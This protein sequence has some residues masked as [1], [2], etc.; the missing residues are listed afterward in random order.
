MQRLLIILLAV[1]G[2]IAIVSGLSGVILG[3]ALIP[4]GAPV[5]TS[6]DS[7]YRFAFV[8]WLAAGVALLWSLFPLR[9]RKSVTQVTL[10]LAFIGGLARL[11]SVIAIG[12]PHPVF[13]TT[14]ALELVVVPLVFLWHARF[15]QR[16]ERAAPGIAET[17]GTTLA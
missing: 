9:E 2:A 5:S 11:A 1:F 8:F 12:W 3:P 15:V 6:V 7:Q 10:A 17:T 16:A 14:L 4:G 13:A